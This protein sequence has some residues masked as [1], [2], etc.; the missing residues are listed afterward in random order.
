VHS[1][2]VLHMHLEKIHGPLRNK[3]NKPS[4]FEDFVSYVIKQFIST[5][6]KL[7]LPEGI[8]SSHVS[9]SKKNTFCRIQTTEN[10]YTLTSD[11]KHYNT[12]GGQWLNSNHKETNE[13]IVKVY[14]YC[15][16][17]VWCLATQNKVKDSRLMNNITL[18]HLLVLLKL[19]AASCNC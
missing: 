19:L 4:Y 1:T 10:I 15:V 7:C 17:L 13:C 3:L 18:P 8:R 6:C 12:Q 5:Q 16:N 11:Y 2:S 14:L 9:S